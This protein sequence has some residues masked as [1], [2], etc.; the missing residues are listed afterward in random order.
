MSI[1][2]GVYGAMTRFMAEGCS[3]AQTVLPLVT[4]ASANGPQWKRLKISQHTFSVFVAKLWRVTDL[5]LFEKEK[6]NRG[7]K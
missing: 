4:V 3:I 1:V 5:G 6:K 7:E 2:R